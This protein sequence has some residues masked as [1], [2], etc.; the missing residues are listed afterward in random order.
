MVAKRSDG[1]RVINLWK[2]VSYTNR[3]QLDIR[4][5]AYSN[6]KKQR[7]KY[8]NKADSGYYSFFDCPDNSI[9]G[10]VNYYSFNCNR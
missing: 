2:I 10:N 7:K 6:A 4:I 1:L 5:L 3:I 9:A 8:R